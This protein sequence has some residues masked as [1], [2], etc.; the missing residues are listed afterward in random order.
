MRL[1]Q[2]RVELFKVGEGKTLKSQDFISE[3]TATRFAKESVLKVSKRNQEEEFQAILHKL[4]FKEGYF[5]KEEEDTVFTS[6]SVLDK[7]YFKSIPEIFTVKNLM[8]K[9]TTDLMQ[10]AAFDTWLKEEQ[11]IYKDVFSKKQGFQMSVSESRHPQTLALQ[12]Y[13]YQVIRLPHKYI[14]GGGST[15]PYKTITDAQTAMVR[16]LNEYLFKHSKK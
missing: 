2:F 4:Y 1:H 5:W 6:S 15:K 3:D 12:G 14:L 9:R 8:L 7:E 13:T 10:K 16:A 11:Y